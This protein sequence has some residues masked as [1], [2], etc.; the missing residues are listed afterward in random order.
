MSSRKATHFEEKIHH[1]VEKVEK[2]H[3]AEYE[4]LLFSL[5][6]SYTSSTYLT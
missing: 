6:A 5:L 1:Q 3:Q 2:V 4:A